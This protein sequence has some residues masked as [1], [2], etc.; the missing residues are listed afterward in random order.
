MSDDLRAQFDRMIAAGNRASAIL[1]LRDKIKYAFE[2]GRRE[3]GACQ[4]WMKSRDCPMERNVN[5]YNRGPSM[6]DPACGKFARTASSISIQRGRIEDAIA[7]ALEHDLP[8]PQL[9][10]AK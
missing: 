1:I 4:H 10:A 7:F 6:S 5:G 2:G 3:C 8:V 9:E